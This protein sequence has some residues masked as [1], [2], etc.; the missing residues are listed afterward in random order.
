LAKFDRVALL[1]CVLIASAMVSGQAIGLPM[2]VDFQVDV[3]GTT[4]ASTIDASDVDGFDED[5]GLGTI[6][7]TVATP[8]PHAVRAY[9]D[10]AFGPVE[11]DEQGSASGT[12]AAG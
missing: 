3:D 7:V 6:E 1:G 8:G 2:L 9:G 11:F 4:V 10:H 12:A 5:T